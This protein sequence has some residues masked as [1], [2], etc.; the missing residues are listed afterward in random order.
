MRTRQQVE[1]HH[2][3]QK[4]IC[5]LISAASTQQDSWKPSADPQQD[6][7]RILPAWQQPDPLNQTRAYGAPPPPVRILKEEFTS[8]GEFIGLSHL[9]HL[10]LNQR[11]LIM[12][13]RGRS[14]PPDGCT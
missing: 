4:G 12:A 7:I 2:H 6:L 8:S 10:K 5:T 9:L 1:L 11:M 13:D 3:P 14:R